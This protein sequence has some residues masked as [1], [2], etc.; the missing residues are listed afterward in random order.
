MAKVSFIEIR[1][2]VTLKDVKIDFSKGDVIFAV[3]K[4]G[5]GKT[6]AT[7]TLSNILKGKFPYEPL[8]PGAEDGCFITQLDNGQRLEWK[9]DEKGSTLD[10]YDGD[11][12]LKGKAVDYV[13]KEMLGA[14][15]KLVDLEHY[16]TVTA[17]EQKRILQEKILGISLADS[18]AKIKREET[19]RT[20][21]NQQ[22][23]AAKAKLVE[24]DPEDATKEEESLIELMNDLNTKRKQNEEE[25][26]TRQKALD[27]NTATIAQKTTAINNLEADAR[28]IE[29]QIEDLKKK[30]KE[31][32][33]QVKTTKAERDTAEKA[34]ELAL[35]EIS[36]PLPVE[37]ADIDAL[38][39]RIDNADV[40]N[41]K[42]R[43]AKAAQKLK[44]E[45]DNLNT[46][47][48]NATAK[49]QKARA[50]KQALLATV[51]IA[52]EGMTFN[53][54]TN[55]FEIDGQPLAIVNL[56]RRIIANMQLQSKFFGEVRLA[57]FEGTTLDDD[58]LRRI[59]DW[60]EANNMQGFIEI[61]AHGAAG[62]EIAFQIADEFLGQPQ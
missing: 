48:I 37:Q 61:V 62:R 12:K 26:R 6:L 60:L 59:A 33:E 43:E 9:F 50:D 4:N 35:A 15:E 19:M 17:P 57:T 13:L 20:E 30:L 1:N 5:L 53:P 8:P 56:S 14:S 52:A 22:L 27:D 39:L 51:P 25:G 2:L 28:S 11:L 44:E 16:I 40:V 7:K 42:I 34:K 49:V 36:K 31:K 55:D 54:E 58:N 46:A 21:F 3:G 24:F 32:T 45:Y 47:V 10:V 38:Q 41:K 29:I 18:D 23:N